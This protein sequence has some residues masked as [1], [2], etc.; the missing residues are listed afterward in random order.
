M[1]RIKFAVNAFKTVLTEYSGSV[2]V[3]TIMGFFDN[4]DDP[5]VRYGFIVT[6]SDSAVFGISEKFVS[7]F[8]VIS[9]FCKSFCI[10][11][12]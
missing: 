2:P 9:G 11:V 7:C 1:L 5:P 3:N 12:A 8:F 4:M 6:R 10:C